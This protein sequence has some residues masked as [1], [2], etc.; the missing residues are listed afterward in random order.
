MEEL[1]MSKYLKNKKGS[2]GKKRL[3]VV[4]FLKGEN[5]S[6]YFT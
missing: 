2:E 6:P 5:E 3:E 1:Y 4:V